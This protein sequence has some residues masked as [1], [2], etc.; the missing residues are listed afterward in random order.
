MLDDGS[1]LVTGIFFSRR[2]SENYPQASG[3]S[4]LPRSKKLDNVSQ[5][6]LNVTLPLRI[7]NTSKSAT[8]TPTA[9]TLVITQ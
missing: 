3:A 6:C 4:I 9:I 8:I 1:I 7:G 5:A 2:C